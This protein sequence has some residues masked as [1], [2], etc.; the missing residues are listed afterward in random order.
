MHT[1]YTSAT[2][3]AVYCD[4]KKMSAEPIRAREAL[5][6]DAVIEAAL[7]LADREGLDAVSFRRVG[8]QLGVTA[9]ALYRYVSSKEELLGAMMDR[10]FGE[11]ELPPTVDSDWRGNSAR[12][13]ARFA[14]CCSH[15]RRRRHCISPGSGRSSPTGCGS[16][17]RC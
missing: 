9:M 2:I 6:R 11:F 15:T 3:Y 13:V 10:V 5:T 17:N 7:Q 1:P 4:V 12:S 14:G 8:T 16:S